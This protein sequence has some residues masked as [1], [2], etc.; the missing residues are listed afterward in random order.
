MQYNKENKVV[1]VV[2]NASDAYAQN[3]LSLWDV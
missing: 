1:D 3:I 2:F